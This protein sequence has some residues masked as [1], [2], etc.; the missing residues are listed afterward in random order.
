MER[1]QTEKNILR[2]L[3]NCETKTKTN[4]T[5]LLNKTYI[6]WRSLGLV[7]RQLKNDYHMKVYW[8]RT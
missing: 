5:K 8:Y 2:A 3:G 4:E 1:K 7:P 6:I